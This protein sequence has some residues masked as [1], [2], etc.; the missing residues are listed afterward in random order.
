MVRPSYN[1]SVGTLKAEQKT[2]PNSAPL[3]WDSTTLIAPKYGTPR[4]LRTAARQNLP[5]RHLYAQSPP[6]GVQIKPTR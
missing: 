3:G 2:H 5:A 1:G 4:T 6:V